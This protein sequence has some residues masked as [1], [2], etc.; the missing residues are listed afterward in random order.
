MNTLVTTKYIQKKKLNINYVRIV[1]KLFWVC[2]E[3]N[4]K[5]ENQH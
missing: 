1:S 2:T 3:T 5:I 4:N